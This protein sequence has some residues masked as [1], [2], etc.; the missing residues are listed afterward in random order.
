M[1]RTWHDEGITKSV[2]VVTKQSEPIVK[3]GEVNDLG[4][5]EV[6]GVGI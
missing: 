6:L 1:Q 3:T 4:I 2:Q 5:S